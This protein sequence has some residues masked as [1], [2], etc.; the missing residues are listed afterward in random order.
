MTS[1]STTDTRRYGVCIPDT[2]SS[3]TS[4]L[5]SSLFSG[6]APED[7]CPWYGQQHPPTR[8][9]REQRGS[10]GEVAREDILSPRPSR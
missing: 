6:L 3:R 7:T 5:K 2:A 10:S 8:G 9:T 1:K 4:T